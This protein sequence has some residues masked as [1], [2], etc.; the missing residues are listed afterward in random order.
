MRRRWHRWPI[1]VAMGGMEGPEPLPHALE[2][3]E[4][5]VER[6]H[7]L[8]MELQDVNRG[9]Y[10]PGAWHPSPLH[11]NF[12]GALDGMLDAEVPLMQAVQALKAEQRRRLR[13]PS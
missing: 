3:I 13:H 4:A 11:S 7:R 10:P 9:N 2:Q 6:L 12:M 8:L 1:L 5:I